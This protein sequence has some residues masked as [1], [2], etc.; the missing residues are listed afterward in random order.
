M[1][2]TVRSTHPVFDVL[3]GRALERTVRRDDMQ[4]TPDGWRSCAISAS[5]L[6][7]AQFRR[8]RN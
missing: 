5:P 6:R 7:T 8:D 1:G 2:R 4:S 3:N